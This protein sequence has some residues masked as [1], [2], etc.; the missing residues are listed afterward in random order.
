MILVYNV[1]MLALYLA[2]AYI[3]FM[4]H[5]IIGVLYI[6]FLVVME[7]QTYREA[8]KYC[9]YHGKACGSG[10]GVI[11]SLFFKKGDPK[12]FCERKL[13]FKDFIPQMLIGMIPFVLGIALLISRGF[14]PVILLAAI[15]PL[16]SWFVVNPLLYGTICKH[17]KQGKNCCPAMEFFNKK[18]K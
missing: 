12:K 10:K 16:L 18:K 6:V 14:N 3:T 11:A 13:S 5:P 9:C 15:Y 1:L 7:L 2:G 4:L 8:C 17:C